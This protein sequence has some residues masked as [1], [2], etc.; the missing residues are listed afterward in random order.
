MRVWGK[1]IGQTCAIIDGRLKVFALIRDVVKS[2][3]GAAALFQVQIVILCKRH[4]AEEGRHQLGLCPA[5]AE[6]SRDK[7]RNEQSRG[8]HKERYFSNTGLMSARSR[9]ASS[10]LH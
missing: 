9:K 4:P 10:F 3:V 6:K 1:K 7:N 2:Q 5:S 8:F